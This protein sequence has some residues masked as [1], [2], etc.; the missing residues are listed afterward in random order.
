MFMY[1][2][3]K[4][5][6]L[7][8]DVHFKEELDGKDVMEN[9]RGKNPRMQTLWPTSKTE[10][11]GTMQYFKT[12]GIFWQG[13]SSWA[14]YIK[15]WQRCI[16]QFYSIC[17][18]KSIRVIQT[19]AT[20]HIYRNVVDLRITEANKYNRSCILCTAQLHEQTN[21]HF[22]ARMGSQKWMHLYFMD[23]LRLPGWNH[24]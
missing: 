7:L 12:S 20:P 11:A 15:S 24:N 5:P 23:F 2:K 16:V 3:N 19:K 18:K 13:P 9:Y 8:I 4:R 1:S 6:E 22:Q 17:M 21:P 14:L 10:K